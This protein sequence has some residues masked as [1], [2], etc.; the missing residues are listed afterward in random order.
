MSTFVLVHGAWGGSYGFRHLRPLL[1]AEGH[2]VFTPSLTGIGERVHLASKMDITLST[3]I[4]DV[5]N[6]IF[7]EDLDDITLLGF[8]YGGMVVTGLLDDLASKVRHLVYL[9]AIVPTDGQSGLDVLGAQGQALESMA[10]GGFVPP[11]PR[12]LDTPEATA[13]SDARR[14]PQ[15]L[16]TITEPVRLA[17]PLEEGGFSRTFIKASADPGEANDSAFWQAAHMAKASPKW[18]YHEI[19]TNHMVPM[20]RPE[21]LAAIL[22]GIASS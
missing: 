19:E 18:G 5:A 8:S 22:L 7:H 14:A 20:T 9:D 21:E 11:I 3:H 16:G 15:P 1:Q 13:W 12:Q 6:M 10:E 2:Q 4:E 17:R